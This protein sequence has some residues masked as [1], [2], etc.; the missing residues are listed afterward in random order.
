MAVSTTTK[1]LGYHSF[2]QFFTFWLKT[3]LSVLSFAVFFTPI[4]FIFIKLKIEVYL[5]KEI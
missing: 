2:G 3:Y 5:E 1:I 4:M